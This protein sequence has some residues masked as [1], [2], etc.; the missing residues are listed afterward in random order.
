MFFAI[1]FILIGL[2]LLLNAMG[3]LPANFWE[4]FWAIIFLT[5]GFNLLFKKNK[6][7]LCGWSYWEEK[8]N[9]RI[10]QKPKDHHQE[11]KEN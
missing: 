4:L 2:F 3:I 6:N 8:F 7:P 10:Q 1:L 11:D 5:F 9:G